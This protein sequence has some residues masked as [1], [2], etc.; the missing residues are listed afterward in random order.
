MG[1]FNKFN[2]SHGDRGF[3]RHHDGPRQMFQAVCNKCGQNCEVPFR[4]TGDRP[5]FCNNCFKSKGKDDSRFAPKSFGGDNA[6][7]SANGVVSKAQF[8]ILNAKLDKILGVL[9]PAKVEKVAKEKKK[10]EFNRV[11]APAKKSKGKKR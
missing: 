5:V 4:P 1:D 6:R 7:P 8:D 3:N 10:A 9:A 2:K 11:R